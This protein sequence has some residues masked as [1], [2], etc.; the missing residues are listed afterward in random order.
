MGRVLTN[1]ISAEFS[2]ESAPGVPT[3]L[4]RMVE[5][6]NITRFGGEITTTPRNPISNSRQRRKGTT[7][8]KT[9]GVTYDGDLTMEVIENYGDLFFF[10]NFVGPVKVDSVT[11]SLAATSTAFTHSAIAAAL[12]AN[13]L[14]YSR[15]FAI[16]SNNGFKVVAAASTTT[17]TN[18]TGGLTAE[19]PTVA[20]NAQ[21][22]VCGVRGAT[23]D[24]Q[25]DANG[26]LISTVLDFTTL[27]LTVGQVIHVG[28]L[29]AANQFATAADFGFARIVSIAANLIQLDKKATTFVLDNGAG[30]DIDLLF[31]RFLRNVSVDHADYLDQTLHWELAEPNLGNPGDEYLYVTANSAGQ[32]TWTL[33]PASKATTTLEF[34][35]QDAVDPTASRLS[36]A[37]TPIVPVRTEALNTA[38]DIARLRITEVD[39]TG[40]TTC[41]TS[42]TARFNNNV[43]RELCLGTLGS[44]FVNVGNFDVDIE[45]QLVFTDSA[46]ISAINQNRT[47][48][49]D[50][51]VRNGDGG[52]FVDLPSVTLGG[53]NQDFPRNESVKINITTT[54]FEDPILHTS[55]SI[56]LFPVLP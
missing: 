51:A 43:G 5:P 46:V 7:T 55:A 37:S 49:M 26:D 40:V 21:F 47:M 34:E 29:V 27:G 16:A 9:A 28:G 24:L 41:F 38:T 4:W 25:I 3:T 2:R 14:V 32:W 23:G 13:T 15:G 17:T 12:P 44:A 1:T 53:G 30:K 39:E 50:W 42:L 36:G 11:G 22:E 18:I 54:P 10:A 52:A 56:S 19:T 6:D 20:Q 48:S 35:G 31:G 33:E 8:D 45:A